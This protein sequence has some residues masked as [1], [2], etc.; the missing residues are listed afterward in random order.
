MGHLGHQ[1]S[2]IP[3]VLS[4]RWQWERWVNVEVSGVG[5]TVRFCGCVGDGCTVSGEL[6][7]GVVLLDGVATARGL[8]VLV[9][10][11]VFTSGL[12]CICYQ[13]VCWVVIAVRAAVVHF[14]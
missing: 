14:W 8:V 12:S 1:R 5:G 13:Y 2:E 7:W 10:A 9:V 11:V 3:Q 6:V 4:P